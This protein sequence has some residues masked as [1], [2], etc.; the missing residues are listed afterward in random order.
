[1]IPETYE[2]AIPN[3][4]FCVSVLR[5]KC[6]MREENYPSGTHYTGRRKESGFGRGGEASAETVTVQGRPA[7][8]FS[9][10]RLSVSRRLRGPSEA[11][12]PP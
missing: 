1:M 3:R 10:G 6:L 2:Q 4:R 5:H 9:S 11:G 8:T 12:A 7:G